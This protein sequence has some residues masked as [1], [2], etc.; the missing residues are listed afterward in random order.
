[1]LALVAGIHVFLSAMTKDVDGRNKSGHDELWRD[2]RDFLRSTMS[3]S[4]GTRLLLPPC[5]EKVGMRRRRRQTQTRGNAPSP[6]LRSPRVR[7][8]VKKQSRSCDALHPSCSVGI[9]QIFKNKR[10][11][12]RSS[13]E[14]ADSGYRRSHDLRFKLRGKK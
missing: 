6:S 8:E 1:M 7:G 13:S 9:K 3:N 12:H 5:G 11:R 14:N 2:L 4:G 10:S